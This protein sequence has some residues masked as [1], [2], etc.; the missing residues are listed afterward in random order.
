MNPIAQNRDKSVDGDAV[1]LDLR[2]AGE[3]ES[4]EFLELREV[5]RNAG[6]ERVHRPLL[7]DPTPGYRGA[8]GEIADMVATLEPTVG[9]VGQVLTAL[10]NWLGIRPQRTI[11]LTIGQDMMTING[12]S[13]AD[14]DRLIDAFVRRVAGASTDHG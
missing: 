5:L 12:L 8:E 6:A 3:L 10:R 13:S 14:E 4:N 7:A 2:F 11:E 1:R 9:V